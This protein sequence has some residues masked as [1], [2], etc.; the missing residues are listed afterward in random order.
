MTSLVHISARRRRKDKV[1]RGLLAAATG[2]ALVPL[3]LILYYLL[4]KGLGA[5]SGSFF[6][7]PCSRPRM[8]APR[9]LTF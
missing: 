8:P 5:W 6:T 7:A 1:M 3:A 4:K 9:A 2:L